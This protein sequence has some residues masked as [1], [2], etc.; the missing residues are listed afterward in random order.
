M[1][2]RLLLAAAAFLPVSIAIAIAAVPGC[3]SD[4]FEDICG[5]L[6]DPDGCYLSFHAETGD[7]C[8]EVKAADGRKSTFA[9]RDKLDICFLRSGGQIVFDPP[10]DLA[11][12]P[13][14]SASFKRLDSLAKECSVV[15]FDGQFSY[16][17]TI[18]G[19]GTSTDA[20]DGAQCDADKATGNSGLTEVAGGTVSVSTPD[21]R[22]VYDVSCA[23]GT[24]HHFNRLD[25]GKCASHAQLL[26]RAEIESSAGGQPPPE[27]TDAGVIDQF[28][29]FV[30]FRISYPPVEAAANGQQ[31]PDK[32]QPNV[33]EYFDCVIPAAAPL[34]SNGVKDGAETDIDCGGDI[35]TQKKCEEGQSC[36]QPSDCASG[37]PC[38]P[39]DDGFSKCQGGGGGSGGGGSGGGGAGGGGGSGGN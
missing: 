8:A 26:P 37:L 22:D 9:S 28:D 18:D 13:L 33:I 35:C 11:N 17:I 2:R 16:S 23:D 34:C 29:G 15:K 30:R 39:G 3:G 21:G 10:L 36:I 5:W 31:I 12:F 6:K 32:T 1:R 19:C 20:G 7:R 24:R 25:T 4:G 27:E 38:K 14:K